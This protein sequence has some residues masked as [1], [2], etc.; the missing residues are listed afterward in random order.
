MVLDRGLSYLDGPAPTTRVPPLGPVL[1]GQRPTLMS[2]P[3]PE[4]TP[5]ETRHRLPVATVRDRP[6][7]DRSLDGPA[8]P[9]GRSARPDR[10]RRARRLDDRRPRRP[11]QGVARRPAAAV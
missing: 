1:A 7:P 6:G 2:S 8:R 3:G 9:R 10:E 5:H 4:E 11:P